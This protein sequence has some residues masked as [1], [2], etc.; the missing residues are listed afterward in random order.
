MDEQTT[1]RT[2]GG[3][4]ERCAR[5][6]TWTQGKRAEFLIALARSANV[7]GSARQAGMS[8]AGA[9]KLRARDPSFAAAWEAA[10]CEG[11]TRLESLMLA[12]ALATM[13]LPEEGQEV[14]AP[15]LI[16]EG[17]ALTLLRMHHAAVRDARMRQAAA[18]ADTIDREDDDDLRARLEATLTQMHVRLTVLDAAR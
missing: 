15:P 17:G 13:T 1:R 10:L 3:V 2:G 11:V 9:Y 6:G 14:A 12:R 8:E 5:A 4:Q 18:V 16:S 7:R